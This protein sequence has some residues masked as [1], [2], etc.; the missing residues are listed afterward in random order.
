MPPTPDKVVLQLNG[1]ALERLIGGSAEVEVALRQQVV[2]SFS[3]KYL[4]ELINSTALQPVA[5]ALLAEVKKHISEEVW[6]SKTGRWATTVNDKVHDLISRAIAQSIDAT[7]SQQMIE[8]AMEQ[9]VAKID[10][11]LAIYSQ[12]M[13]T[14]AESK[15]ASVIQSLPGLAEKALDKAFEER[16]RLEVQ[17]RLDIAVRI[18]DELES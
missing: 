4:K 1:P 3:L 2:E 5:N 6:D 15:A 11:R 7:V 16:V 8:K 18:R 12:R 13:V 14:M 9:A 10:E 17:R